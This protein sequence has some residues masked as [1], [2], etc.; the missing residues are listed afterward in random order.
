MAINLPGTEETTFYT[1]IETMMVTNNVTVME[2]VVEWC[3][4]RGIEI[5]YAAMLVANN[6]D[7]KAKLQCEAEGLNF[8]KKSKRVPI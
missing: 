8:L 3:D 2:A 4:R 7:L 6:A 1:D 5:E